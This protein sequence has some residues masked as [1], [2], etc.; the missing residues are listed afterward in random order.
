MI[1]INDPELQQ[2]QHDA[3]SQHSTFTKLTKHALF[4]LPFRSFFLCA[5]LASMVSLALWSAHLSGNISFLNGELSITVWHVH[6]MLFAFGATVAVGFIL[7]AVQTWT[8]QASIKGLPVIALLV[9]WFLVR[10]CL[11]VNSSNSVYLGVILQSVWWLSVISVFA[12]LTLKAKNRRNYLFIPL[13]SALMLLNLGVLLFDLN[14]RT[15]LSLHFAKTVVLM[16]G[17]M[18][19]IMGGRVIPF[20]T[21]AA[22]RIGKITTPFFLTPML[23]VTSIAGISVFFVGKFISLPFTPAVLM[24]ASG[25]LHIVRLAFWHSTVTVNVPLLW[26]LHL[27]YF[28]LGFGLILLGSSYLQPYLQFNDALHLITIGAMALMIIAMMSRVSLGHT[29]R[30]LKTHKAVPISFI[31]IFSAALV[32]VFLP[33]I[34]EYQLAWH[35]STTLWIFASVIFLTIYSPI[36]SKPRS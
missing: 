27:S 16:F 32:R 7:T 36:L 1:S 35:L 9:L 26:S 2:L 24:I 30:A 10:I 5:V 13:L 29:G 18:M 6:E 21:T 22:T 31:L 34:Q 3:N 28:C 19:G 11:L 20:F 8:G 4:D 15:D 17:L 25:L 23:L 14:G 12:K 33:L